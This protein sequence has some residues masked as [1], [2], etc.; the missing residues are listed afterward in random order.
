[1]MKRRD[2]E[3]EKGRRKEE[4]LGDYKGLKEVV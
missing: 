1:M 3:V 4:N 2:E